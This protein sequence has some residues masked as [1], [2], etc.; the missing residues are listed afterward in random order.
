MAAESA[1]TQTNE[2]IEELTGQ[3]FQQANEMVATE[4]RARARLEERVLVLVKRAEENAKRL[5]VL[6]NRLERIER[7]RG[8][9]RDRERGKDRERS[10]ECTEMEKN[11]A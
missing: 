3:L 2:E 1:V 4:R 8:L 10:R 6:E 9:L 7:V 11:G 5:E